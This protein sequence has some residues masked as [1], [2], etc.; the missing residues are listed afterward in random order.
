MALPLFLLYEGLLLLTSVGRGMHVRVG[1]DVWIKQ[2]LGAFGVYGMQAL[3]VLVLVAG[4]AVFWYERRRNVP[5]RVRYFGWM[6]VE[7]AGYAVVLALLVGGVVGFIFGLQATPLLM[8]QVS[9]LPLPTLLIL[10]I[11]AGLYEEL[12]FRVLLVGGLYLGLRRLL[13]QPR[14]AYPIAAVV[15]ALIFSAVHYIGPLGDPFAP[16]SFTFRFLFGLA[17]N[18]LFLWRGFAIAAWTHALYDV[19]V[20]TSLLG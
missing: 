3:A 10:S 2:L 11:G 14:W 7:S 6:I 13:Q 15:G 19:F 5:L 9:E 1:A 20:V 18:A 8:A 12:F 4:I 16:A 17:L